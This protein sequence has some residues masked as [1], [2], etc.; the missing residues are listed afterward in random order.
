MYNQGCILDLFV[1][2]LKL[3]FEFMCNPSLGIILQHQQL[4]QFRRLHFEHFCVRGKAWANTHCL[5][6][7]TIDNAEFRK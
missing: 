4:F 3:G 1:C 2:K 6:E 5:S 7:A